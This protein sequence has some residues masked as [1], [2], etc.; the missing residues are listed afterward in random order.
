[1]GHTTKTEN[2]NNLIGLWLLTICLLI[3]S[4][5]IIGGAT[6]LTNSGLSITEWKPIMGAIPPLT[7]QDWHVAFEKYKLI[8][9]YKLE[10]RG[11]SLNEFKYIFWWEWFHRF[12]GRFIGIVFLVPMLLFWVSGKF[13]LDLKLKCSALFILGGLQGA[14][15]WY[16]VK[17]GLVDRVDVSQYRLAAHLGLA[18]FIFAATY[19]V[20]LGLKPITYHQEK[21]TRMGFVKFSGTVLVIGLFLQIVLGAFVAGLHAGLSHNTWP[22]MDGSII[23]A[24]LF[25][26]SPWYLNFFENVLTV[27]FN[28]RMLA[29]VLLIWTC[30]HLYLVANCMGEGRHLWSIALLLIGLLMQI[31]LGI[32]TLL[33]IVPISLGLVHQAGALFVLLIAITHLHSLY[34]PSDT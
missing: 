5:V 25:T 10:N 14:L 22:L 19:W 27:Q 12:L 32:W 23:P 7:D 9:E 31:A 21:L 16:M 18:I 30:Y 4:M 2:D 11:M 3:F 28:H 26:M 20:Y 29:Y 8:P 15:G 34:Y 13:T 1:M 6:R 17:S 33:A 24:G